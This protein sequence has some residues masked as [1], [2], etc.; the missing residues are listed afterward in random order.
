MSEKGV[1]NFPI[2]LWGYLFLLLILSIYNIFHVFWSSD[3]KHTYIYD[4]K[5]L[6]ADL[7]TLSLW[8][9]PLYFGNSLCL[10]VYYILYYS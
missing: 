2:M 9:V 1:L 7:D 4:E 8:N 10:K 5:S 3:I 6:T